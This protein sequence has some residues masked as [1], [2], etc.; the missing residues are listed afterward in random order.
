MRRNV[1]GLSDR[2][3]RRSHALWCAAY[4]PATPSVARAFARIVSAYDRAPIREL[5][6]LG[7]FS[8]IE[9]GGAAVLARLAL[10]L[11][12]QVVVE[13]DLPA[14]TPGSGWPGTALAIMLWLLPFV[15]AA[16]FVRW[17]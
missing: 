10:R 8:V 15:G 14:E 3:G 12:G 11:T 1:A 17:R 9:G 2:A 5:V 16:A 7:L 13:R 4:D 6:P